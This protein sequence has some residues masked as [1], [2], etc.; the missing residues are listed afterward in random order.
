M[1]INSFFN[2]KFNKLEEIDKLSNKYRLRIFI[3]IV[4]NENLVRLLFIFGRI[5]LFLTFF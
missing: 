5:R 3:E 2:K 1:S 4:E